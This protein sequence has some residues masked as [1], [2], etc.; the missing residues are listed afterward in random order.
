VP[1]ST[2]GRPT[3]KIRDLGENLSPF[4][5]YLGRSS[6]FPESFSMLGLP[7]V[8][9][10]GAIAMKKIGVQHEPESSRIDHEAPARQ[11][12]D[13]PLLEHRTRMADMANGSDRVMRQ[14]K[15]QDAIDHSPRQ[16]ARSRAFSTSESVSSAPV[17]RVV[18]IDGSAKIRNVEKIWAKIKDGALPAR[19]DK[20]ILQEIHRDFPDDELTLDEIKARIV[21]KRAPPPSKKRK[22]RSDEKPADYQ[23]RTTDPIGN[24]VDFE[25]HRSFRLERRARRRLARSGMPLKGRNVYVTTYATPGESGNKRQR[26]MT[27]SQ[28][29]GDLPKDHETLNEDDLVSNTI[30]GHSEAQTDN[31]EKNY[32][33]VAGWKRESEATT[34]EQCKDC[35]HNYPSQTL[36]H[37]SH[38]FP[39]SAPEDHLQNA[40]LRRRVIANKGKKGDMVLDTAEQ[41]D[42]TAAVSSATYARQFDPAQNP[43]MEAAAARVEAQLD[44]SDEEY[45]DDEV[46]VHMPPFLFD[47]IKS[48]L[49]E[50]KMGKA[51][52]YRIPASATYS[53]GQR[54]SQVK[55]IAERR[56]KLAE[57]LAQAKDDGNSDDEEGLSEGESEFEE[58]K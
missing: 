35:R 58:E 33:R 32:A 52:V 19:G 11:S 48:Q 40:N 36:E 4:C 2:P 29:P 3:N 46:P 43:A 12:P 8:D 37:H 44:D 28:P 38:G 24:H 49:V 31:I 17:Q 47:G 10:Q 20:K 45:S 25:T 53:L 41:K 22:A 34:R 9:S 15:W 54:A 23:A 21:A 57:K 6:D 16:T 50:G 14:M 1:G 7:E 18:L 26:I 42:F 13:V 27:V 30:I 55:W 5:F 39:Y 56:K 51:P